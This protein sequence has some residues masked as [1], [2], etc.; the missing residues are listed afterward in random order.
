MTEFGMVLQ[1]WAHAAGEKGIHRKDGGGNGD[2][3]SIVRAWTKAVMNQ[4]PGDFPEGEIPDDD[5]GEEAGEEI[6]A[7][8]DGRKEKEAKEEKEEKGADGKGRLPPHDFWTPVLPPD[9]P[10]G[11]LPRS[12]ESFAV[13]M[14]T[15]TGAD[16]TGFAM[17]AVVAC[18]AVTTDD[19]RL[20]VL[21]NSTDWME[22]ARIW[23]ALIGDPS[24]KKTPIIKAGNKTGLRHRS[25][26]LPPIQHAE[27]VPRRR[28]QG[29]EKVRAAGASPPDAQRHH[30]RCGTGHP[31]GLSR[32]GAAGA[33][34]AVGV[35]QLDGALQPGKGDRSFWLRTYNG[36][37][38][39]V[40]RVNRG[41]FVIPNLSVCM[42]GGAQPDIARLIAGNTADDGLIQ[43]ITPIILR[44]GGAT[45]DV[46]PSPEAAGYDSLIRRLHQRRPPAGASGKPGPLMLDAGG[47]AVRAELE[48]EHLQISRALEQ[49]GARKLSAAII[50][51][52]GLFARLCI[53][54]HAVET[55]DL[56][57]LPLTIG[58]DVAHRVASFMRRFLR[59]HLF[60]FYE[61][62]SA[63]PTTRT[64]WPPSPGTSSPTASTSSPT[65]RRRRE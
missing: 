37:P 48:E 22:A 16:A 4:A 3:R 38:Y 44:R 55:I 6:G 42:L 41:T 29:R 47:M 25:G 65:A 30:S 26:A 60:A 62:T 63:L 5:S 36:G 27:A 64:G 12:I 50:K 9:L 2:K 31:Q 28:H 46:G 32:R 23:V 61:A 53:G 24:V 59:P 34:R 18:A 43:R 49:A 13:S 40:S 20:Q 8:D 15:T 21:R 39:Q 11:L 51:Q 35:L 33:G 7:D 57:A 19:I 52:D 45:R 17:A 10:P 54:W 56:P 58:S 14:A 1:T